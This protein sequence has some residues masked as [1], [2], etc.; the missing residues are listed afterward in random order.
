MAGNKGLETKYGLRASESSVLEASE[1][2]QG[3]WNL[4]PHFGEH[5][6]K[7]NTYS[8]YAKLKL[9]GIPLLGRVVRIEEEGSLLMFS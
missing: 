3:L 5:V 2:D 9:L 8:T 7:Y 6:R 4:Q 1:V